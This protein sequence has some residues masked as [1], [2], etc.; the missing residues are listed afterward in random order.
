MT[1]E[2]QY[3]SEI[4]EEWIEGLSDRIS[5]QIRS[6]R[7]FLSDTAKVGGG[8]LALSLGGSGLAA[9]DG[10]DHEKGDDEKKMSDV[11]VLNFALTLEKLEATFYTEGQQKFSEGEFES[12]EFA[13]QF[14]D[15]LR[16][17]SYDY[18]NLIRDH[19]QAHV[20]TITQVIQKL[21][22]EPVSGLQFEFPYET[23]GEYVGL[24]QTFENLGVS[25]YDGAI[26]QIQNPE[27]QTAGA[28]IA[29]VEARHASYLNL[30]NSD[31]P[32][33]DAFDEPKSMEEVQEAAS[34]FIV[35]H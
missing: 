24:A 35:S 19:E 32:F 16:F 12:S 25:A 34:Q 22:G 6:R 3:D 1:D 33:P 21:G 11:D 28:T 15:T 30:L 8:A 23:V 2:S 10:D 9:A 27:L 7:G 5:Q 13:K 20:D 14:R 29:T 17:S 26:A 18:F 31:I 4:P